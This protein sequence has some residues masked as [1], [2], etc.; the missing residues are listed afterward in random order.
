MNNRRYAG[1]SA[2]DA[3]VDRR[4]AAAD[5]LSILSKSPEEIVNEIV[6]DLDLDDRYMVGS[7]G[8]VSSGY[9]ELSPADRAAASDSAAPA[10]RA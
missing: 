8:R 3:M 6:R 1:P 4:S 9:A 10:A 2:R 5:T 7:N